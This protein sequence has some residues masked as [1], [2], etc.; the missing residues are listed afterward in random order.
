MWSLGFLPFPI[1]HFLS[2][3]NAT[4]IFNTQFNTRDCRYTA[5]SHSEISVLCDRAAL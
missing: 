3:A 5:F 1:V 2:N 4:L